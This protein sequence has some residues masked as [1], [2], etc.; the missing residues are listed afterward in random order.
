MNFDL[1]EIDTKTLS[2]Q[3][4]PMIVKRLESPEPLIARNGKPVTLMVLGPDSHV[5]RD[6]TRRQV[7]K[8][9]ARMN[10]PSKLAEIDFDEADA[11]TLDLLASCTVG[12]ENVLDTDG[13]AIAWSAE[14]AR[15][16][17][18]AYPVVREQVD[19]FVAARANFIKASSGN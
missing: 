18:A 14:N 6:F 9:L 19:T 4:V 1:A 8:R 2:E 7:R 15:K 12:W 13:K 3:G 16:L 5:Y 17:L 11:E 10:D